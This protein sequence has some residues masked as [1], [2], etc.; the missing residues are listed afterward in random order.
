MQPHPHEADG[1]GFPRLDGQIRTGKCLQ[2]GRAKSNSPLRS[3]VQ[4]QPMAA[5]AAC[6]VESVVDGLFAAWRRRSAAILAGRCVLANLITLPAVWGVTL[7]AFAVSGSIP[8]GF[9]GLA[10]SALN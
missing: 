3:R 9:A 2:L 7:V 6:A 5:A 10:I 8:F 4:W 1:V